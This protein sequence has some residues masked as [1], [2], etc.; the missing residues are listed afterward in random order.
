MDA[1]QAGA[2]VRRRPVPDGVGGQVGLVRISK[3]QSGWRHIGHLAA[4]KGM[5]SNATPD[6]HASN[7]INLSAFLAANYGGERFGSDGIGS[8]NRSGSVR[9]GSR[10]EIV[11]PE[12]RGE[13]MCNSWPS[14]SPRHA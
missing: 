6:D 7:R 9:T 11:G 5:A 2:P 3:F 10:D 8:H 13:T 14:P 4:G 1:G 12:R